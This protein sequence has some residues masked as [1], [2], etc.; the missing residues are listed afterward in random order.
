[1][2]DAKK[3]LQSLNEKSVWVFTKQVTD[4]DISFLATKLFYEMPKN[5]NVEK[6]F[7]EHHIDYDIETDRHRALVIPQLFGLITKTPFYQRGGQYNKEKVTE[8][9]DLIK[10]N[11]I[12]FK[13]EPFAIIKNSEIYNQIKTEQIL[14]IKIHAII[15][16]A[17]NNSDYNILPVVFI[18]KVL[19][20][21]QQ[22]YS[23]NEISIDHLYTYI[24]TCKSYQ[25]INQAVEFIKNKAPISE[26]VKKYKDASRVLASIKK[27][28][29][30]FN[31]TPNT[32][33]INPDFDDYFYNNFILKY[34]FKELHKQ[35]IRDIDYSYFLYTNQEFNIDLISIPKKS[36]I[37]V[38]QPKKIIS[39]FIDE[40]EKETTYLEKVDAIKEYNVNEDA[41]NEAYKDAPLLA[42]NISG[43]K[44]FKVNPL[45]GKIAIQ[46]ACYCCEN[47]PHH[48]TF[49]SKKT[50]KKY[51]EAHHLIPI[52][53]QEEIW[54]RYKINV[55]C[56]ENLIS[57][58][59]TCHKA[60]H[61]GKKEVKINI[62]ENLFKKVIPRY[63]SINFDIS[64]AEIKSLYNIK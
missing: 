14:K 33:S 19:K 2:S 59:P 20:K 17:N 18:Y 9:F 32:I 21:L 64:L 55:D 54:E 45:L 43:K 62:I 10:N 40:E 57:L 63:K 16:T 1:M 5:K 47:N 31:V 46:K 3:Y 41:G 25:Q 4:F 28:I 53:F 39:T 29:N 24:M 13:N 51:M 26:Y 52:C 23:I 6:Y 22:K 49:I 12:N 8:T 30:L 48:K 27:N 38:N 35:L 36:K 37:K 50:N 61:Y 58:C 42:K 56:I 60:I 7:K 34:D 15:D 44:R 11:F